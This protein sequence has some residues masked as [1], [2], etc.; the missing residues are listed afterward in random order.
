LKRLDAQDLFDLKYLRDARI[1]P[2]GRWIAYGISRTDEREHFEIWISDTDGTRQER[3][4]YEGNA[5]SPRWAPNGRCLAFAGDGQLR[6]AM[7]PELSVSNP[8]TSADLVVE[9]APTWSPDGEQLAVALSQ[10]CTREG[11]LRITRNA[12]RSDGTGYIDSVKQQIYEVSRSTETS[13][14]L[15]PG[16]RMC[17]QPEWS[18]C[19]RRILY[20][21]TD[22]SSAYLSFPARLVTLDMTTGAATDIIRGEWFVACARWLPGGNSIAVVGAPQGTLT[23]PAFSLWIVDAVGPC[24]PELRTPGLIGNIGFFVEH[25]MPVTEWMYG[26]NAITVLDSKTILATVQRRGS[27]EIWRMSPEGAIVLTPLI[28][29]DRS[30]IVL[31]A[32][33]GANVLVF[34]TTDLNS[35]SELSRSPLNGHQERR[36][37]ALNDELL[38]GWPQTHIERLDVKSADGT[39]VEAWFLAPRD[40]E[41]PLPTVLYI[42][43]GP[44]GATGHGFRF[45]FHLLASRGFGVLFANFRGSTGYGEA[46]TRAIMGDWGARGYPDHIG[47]VDAA[48]ARGFAEADRLGVWGHSHGGFATC[49]IVGHSHRFK[50]AIAQAGFVNFATLYYLSD[51]P[52]IF[53]RDLGGRPHEIPDVYRACSP[54]TY[55]HRC[56]TPTLLLH[57]E[58][59]LRCPISEAEQFHRALHDVG[60][61]AELFRI[62]E[63]SHSGDST[64]PLNARRAQNE[65]LL[66]WFE[67]YL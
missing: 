55:A 62:P 6:L 40:R 54:I 63:C 32:N 18:P 36:L 43:G 16:E 30:A 61:V 11:P 21:A 58:E 57:G 26:S 67:R 12:F 4:P 13:R 47:A 29:G 60:C 8:L 10:Q 31:D 34:A 37:T 48:I 27:A 66:D 28:T 49:W 52:G 22:D 56:T 24:D 44:F 38:A 65:A 3:L 41:R 14:C 1:S 7:F 53:S 59:D 35:P 15:T 25:D 39:E 46:F 19:G 5:A 51:I 23:I 42:H 17:V 33:R 9:G 45:D 20:L 64:G 50:A 2:D